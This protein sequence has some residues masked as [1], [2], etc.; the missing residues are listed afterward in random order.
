[1]SKGYSRGPSKEKHTD[2][3]VRKKQRNGNAK[4][5]TG[6]SSKSDPPERELS[7]CLTK[8]CKK[9][10]LEKYCAV[11]N[12]E[13]RKILLRKL[14]KGKSRDGCPNALW[15]TT[16]A[17]QAS[18]G[19]GQYFAKLADTVAVVVNC[20]YGVDQ[21]ALSEYDVRKCA[22]AGVFVETLGLLSP[23]LMYLARRKEQ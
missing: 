1:M 5:R 11:T 3:T 17:W 12:M 13:D 9:M 2:G 22:D 7:L 21:S 15:K 19:S 6:T 23:I 18:R 14:Y 4:G 20:D 16:G 8:T 10:H